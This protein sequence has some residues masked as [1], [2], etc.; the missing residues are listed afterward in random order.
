MSSIRTAY[1]DFTKLRTA[2]V[3][4]D[5]DDLVAELDAYLAQGFQVKERHR[6]PD[7]GKEPADAFKIATIMWVGQ[8]TSA[9]LPLFTEIVTKP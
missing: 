4:D 7:P 3:R 2:L 5:H 9:R 8:D 1:E 6:A